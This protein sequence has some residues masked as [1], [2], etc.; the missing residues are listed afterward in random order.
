MAPKHPQKVHCESL[1]GCNVSQSQHGW[2]EWNHQPVDF[3]MA[4]APTALKSGHFSARESALSWPSKGWEAFPRLNWWFRGCLGAVLGSSLGKKTIGCH[5]FQMK[6]WNCG[7]SPIFDTNPQGFG[8][9]YVEKITFSEG[10]LLV[11]FGIMTLAWVFCKSSAGRI[12]VFSKGSTNQV[13]TR[14]KRKCWLPKLCIW[15]HSISLSP[16][17]SRLPSMCNMYP[18]MFSNTDTVAPLLPIKLVVS[19]KK[20][21]QIVFHHYSRRILLIKSLFLVSCYRIPFPLFSPATQPQRH[22]ICLHIA[23]GL[24]RRGL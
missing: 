5:N 11:G 22:G 15:I 16:S 2:K 1:G 21:D 6:R 23:L 13:P 3:P 24:R 17:L 10:Y 19:F 14:P 18:N 4:Q 7:I 12:C 20:I 8:W 9:N